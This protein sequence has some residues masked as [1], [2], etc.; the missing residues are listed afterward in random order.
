MFYLL[1][2]GVKGVCRGYIGIMEKNVETTIMGVIGF[3]GLGFEVL[4]CRV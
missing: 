2:G 1:K 4:V 3:K